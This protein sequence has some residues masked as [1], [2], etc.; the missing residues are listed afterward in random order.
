[1]AS[2]V[3]VIPARLAATRLPGKPMALIGDVPM[4]VQVMRRAME[5][6]IAP[7]VV[8]CDAEEIADAV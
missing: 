3:I 6:E 1:M 2:S 5:A 7:V 8:A 4:V